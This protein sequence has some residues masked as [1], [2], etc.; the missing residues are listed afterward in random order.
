MKRPKID[1]FKFYDLVIYAARNSMGARRLATALGSRR[2]RDDLPERYKRRRPFFRG[3]PSPMVVNWGSTVH[4]GWLEDPRL[5]LKPIIVNGGEP[6]K[7]AIDKL[8]FFQRASGIDGVPL[9]RWTESREDAAK[10]I[11]KGRPVVCRT[12]LGG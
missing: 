7:T 12:Q 6:V 9:P 4:P 8:S 10:W 2:W 3:N 11:E 1:K 5:R